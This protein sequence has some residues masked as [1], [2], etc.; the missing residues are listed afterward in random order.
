MNDGKKFFVGWS[1]SAR[2]A[3]TK[4]S[5]W[6]VLLAVVIISIIT[7]VLLFKQTPFANSRFDFG[8]ETT[9]TGTI[10]RT[11]APMLKVEQPL[12]NAAVS[13]PL[14]GFGKMGVNHVLDEIEKDLDAPLEN[15]NVTLHGTLIHYDT[16]TLMEL[17]RGMESFSH[18]ELKNE[19]APA[20]EI[21]DLGAKA[22][23]GEIVV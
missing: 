11:P 2:G 1:D 3:V 6:Y 22:I 10:Y 15:Y 19:P 12:Y 17:T 18:I 23:Y 5:R 9:L 7:A 13:I 8:S 20:R 16:K 14:V 21:Q 4:A